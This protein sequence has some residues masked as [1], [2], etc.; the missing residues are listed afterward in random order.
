MDL[1]TCTRVP[2]L[3]QSW[4]GVWEV[5]KVST[6]SILRDGLKAGGPGATW[7]PP[8]RAAS[9]AR[10]PTYS[11]RRRA[12]AGPWA[13]PC[14][15]RQPCAHTAACIPPAAG[16]WRQS[17]GQDWVGGRGPRAHPQ[18][19]SEEAHSRPTRRPGRPITSLGA[20]LHLRMVGS[21]AGL[22]Q[23]GHRG[24]VHRPAPRSHTP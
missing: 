8:H 5:S 24:P 1:C 10:G 22:S 11:H 4:A 6:L 9:P 16:S 14:P 13:A 23:R 2:C 17:G 12:P 18:G 19:V 20:S 21:Q 15:E 7:V 3:P